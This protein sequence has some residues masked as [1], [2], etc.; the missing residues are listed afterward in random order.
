MPGIILQD[1]KKFLA[2]AVILLFTGLTGHSVLKAQE[3]GITLTIVNSS[4]TGNADGKIEV[5]ID[6]GI[7]PFTV[8]LFDKAPWK[9]GTELRR[10]EYVNNRGVSFEKLLPGNYY[11]IIE[12]S[13][14][15][16]Y[17]DTAVIGIIS[18]N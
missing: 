10:Q 4:G 9:G 11:I 12:D 1:M 16:P 7:P 6:E 2:I 5:T 8:L 17:A 18:N 13:E 3:T 14:K 15:N